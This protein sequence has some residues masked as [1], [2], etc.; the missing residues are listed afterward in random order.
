MKFHV[1]HV[2]RNTEHHDKD[3]PQRPIQ[4]DA[5]CHHH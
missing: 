1:S 5:H 2:R 4:I 3:P